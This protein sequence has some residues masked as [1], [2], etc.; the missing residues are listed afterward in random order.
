MLDGESEVGEIA[1]YGDV[2]RILGTQIFDQSVEHVA[3]VDVAAAVLPIEPAKQALQVPM[4]EVKL[5]Q[6]AEMYV[7][8]V[9]Q[10]KFCAALVRL[11]HRVS[12][13]HRGAVQGVGDAGIL[14]STGVIC[15][16]ADGRKA[17][18]P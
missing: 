5:G 13:C 15:H 10:G 8:Q 1:C 16:N 7:R 18:N 11:L 17:G 4:P 9:R 12:A 14:G 2:V 3:A 6:W